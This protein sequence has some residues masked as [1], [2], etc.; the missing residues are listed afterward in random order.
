MLTFAVPA[1]LLAGALAALV[2]LALHLIRRRPPSR[3]PLPTAR[4]L[5]ED[6][7]T[8]VRLSRPTDLPL[9]ALRMLLLVLAGAAF[10]R[11]R[12]VPAPEGT[13]EV[14]LLD[15]GAAMAAG[16]G[17]R[18]AVDLARR[19]LLGPEGEARGELVLFDTAATRIPR[20]RITPA[21]FDSLAA[22]RPTAREVRYAAAVR[23]ILPAARELRGADSVRVTLLSRPRWGAWSDGLA[24]LRRAA[25]AGGIAMP[26]LGAAPA[27]SDSARA[28][29]DAKRAL[30]IGSPRAGGYVSA[31]LAAT[32]WAVD[33]VSALDGLPARAADLYVVLAPTA[34]A[35]AAAL[36]ERGRAGATVLVAGP[37]ATQAL[38]RALP[39]A[40]VTREGAPGGGLWIADD[41]PLLE[42]SAAATGAP[43]PGASVVAAWDDGRPA[44]A[45]ARLGRGC[46]V[47]AATDLEGGR[48][49]LSA[50]YPRA[51]DRLA[52]GCE[53]SSAA[54]V[55]GDAPLDAGARAVLRGTGTA[56]VAANAIP[57]SGGGVPL[58]RWILAAALLVAAIET[59]IAYRPRA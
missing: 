11:P 46:V 20:R 37:G 24:P 26:E 35:A 44:A 42:G 19:S 5:S 38:A 9:L 1:F 49:P 45:A 31:A 55:D 54:S 2:P 40:G 21:L 41:L 56:V 14:V 30:V 48:M 28:P 33:R 47:F 57:G 13:S 52:R 23:A 39:W 32:G 27:P 18:R 34:T 15:R 4:F 17:W 12:W 16:D 25:W 36:E 10:A 6:P 51:L 58:G 7:R 59:L 22:A 29:G 3:A 8:S 53:S 43:K 50:A